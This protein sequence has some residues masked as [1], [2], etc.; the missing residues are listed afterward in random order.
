VGLVGSPIAVEAAPVRAV[1]CLPPEVLL[2][3]LELPL[4][5]F[6]A[7]TILSCYHSGSAGWDD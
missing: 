1:G 5:C 3:V 7:F 4:G 6:A 2:T